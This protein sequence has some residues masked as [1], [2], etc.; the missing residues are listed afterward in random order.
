MGFL[1]SFFDY[2]Y[3]PMLCDY[4][5]SD[6][7]EDEN[8]MRMSVRFYEGQIQDVKNPISGIVSKQYVRA[9]VIDEKKLSYPK[10]TLL[11][12]VHDALKKYL[13]TLNRTPIDQQKSF[14]NNSLAV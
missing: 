2:F 12:D 11:N 3:P 5:I 6:L 10:G 14:T 13:T 8:G 4:K 7:I 9:A 1:L